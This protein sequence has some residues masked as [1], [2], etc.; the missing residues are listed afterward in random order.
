MPRGGDNP[1]V[2]FRMKS[3]LRNELGESYEATL[4][5]IAK[6]A[7]FY[8]L[9]GR[10]PTENMQLLHRNG[11][12]AYCVRKEF[13]GLGAGPGGDVGLYG[14]IIEDVSAACSSTGQALAVHGT[15]CAAINLLGSRDQIR[16]LSEEVV[17]EGAVYGFFGSE[18]TQRFTKD[19]G[20][21]GYDA[22]VRRA[23]G[24]WIA[25]GQKFF[26]TNSMGAKRF[27]FF[28]MSQADGEQGLAVPIIAV[29][30]PGVKVHDTWDNIG[31]RATSSGA[32]DVKEVFVADEFML[33]RPG[34][35]SQVSPVLLSSF[36]L[37]FA[38]ELTGIA[39]GGLDFTID[40]LKNHTKAPA[41]L[42][43]LGHD[44]HVQGRLGEMAV[45]VEA[46]RAIVERAVQAVADAD[47]DPTLAAIAH[48][49][50]LQA[51]IQASDAAIEVGTRLFQIC[52][53]RATTRRAGADRFWR[54]ARTLSLHDVVDKQRAAVGRDLLGL[55]G[56]MGHVLA[57]DAQ[58]TNT[59]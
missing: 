19:G 52:G 1:E 36:Q 40:Y 47:R 33:G 29:D 9:E 58:R 27:L 34:A 54:N 14:R 12:L 24:G 5:E 55:E 8:D 18:P 56:D 32:V 16:R 53:A 4:A 25:N 26:S 7:Q 57:S 6:R 22:E 42:P 45:L 50:V 44:P 31:Q 41:G 10:F 2:Q 23:P 38:L 48:R 28:A 30:A 35:F 21:P 37:T 43:T 39:R 59:A 3:D 20:R 49:R 15:A 17:S 13:G 11:L 46:T 51:K